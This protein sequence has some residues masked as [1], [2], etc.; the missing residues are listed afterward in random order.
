M[1]DEFSRMGLVLHKGK[2]SW[3]LRHGRLRWAPLSVRRTIVT[4]WNWVACRLIGHDIVFGVCTDCCKKLTCCLG[5]GTPLPLY[6]NVVDD[7]ESPHY[8]CEGWC[9][10]ED[11]S[12]FLLCC[13]CYDKDNAGFE[14]GQ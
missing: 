7:G 13:V 6:D 5:C 1:S 10:V 11:E 12:H 4:V 8:G 14:G 3:G 2:L 9:C